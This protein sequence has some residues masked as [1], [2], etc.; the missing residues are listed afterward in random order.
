MANPNS[1]YWVVPSLK[2]Q[3][4]KFRSSHKSS[5]KFR[6]SHKSRTMSD[7]VQQISMQY[8]KR[9]VKCYQEKEQDATI[10]LP[11]IVKTTYKQC[12]NN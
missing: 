4:S 12:A 10:V 9:V 5:F 1:K 3:A 6:S 11:A 8:P 7:R 2:G